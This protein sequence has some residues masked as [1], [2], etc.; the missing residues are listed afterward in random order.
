MFNKNFFLGVLT[1]LLVVGI[2]AAGGLFVLRAFG[3][4]A[5][6]EFGRPEG[7]FEQRFD[8]E[9]Q[10]DGFGDQGHNRFEGR[11]GGEFSGRGREHSHASFSPLRG[12]GGIL[13]SLVLIGLI[14]AAVVGGQK[15]FKRYW[16]RP[17][18]PAAISAS[19]APVDGPD[20]STAE[21]PTAPSEPVDEPLASPSE[22]AEPV[23]ELAAETPAVPSE[24]AASADAPDETPPAFAETPGDD[25][26]KPIS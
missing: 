25:D 15:L 11:G 23:D 21:T 7:R 24:P 19:V 3:P 9:L 5:G 16:R 6:A 14:I 17:T 8:R 2:L 12:I 4:G 26:N 10:P 20:E 22:P 1:T 18:P 13:G